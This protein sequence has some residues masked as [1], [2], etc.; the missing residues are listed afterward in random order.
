M[1]TTWSTRREFLRSTAS[2]LLAVPLAG[3][4]SGSMPVDCDGDFAASTA[5]AGHSHTLCVPSTDLASP[6]PG[7]FTYTSSSSGSPP[8]THDVSLSQVQLAQ[9][10]AGQPVKVTSGASLDHTHDFTIQKM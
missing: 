1:S 9:L 2:W 8:H 6:P 3:C 5:S 4:A 10:A 7:G